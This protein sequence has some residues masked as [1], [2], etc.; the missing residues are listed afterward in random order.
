MACFCNWQQHLNMALFLY[1]MLILALLYSIV[2]YNMFAKEDIASS[3]IQ[4]YSRRLL[5]VYFVYAGILV[6]GSIAYCM[7][8]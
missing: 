5:V 1:L 6:L 4:L 3:L 7:D 2:P 8:P